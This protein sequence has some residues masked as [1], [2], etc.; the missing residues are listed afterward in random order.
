M[1]DRASSV[2][3]IEFSTLAKRPRAELLALWQEHVQPGVPPRISRVLMARAIAWSIQAHRYG[4]YSF[5]T[6]ERLKLL[7]GAK[8]TGASL[9]PGT[10]LVR[11]WN[12]V[13]HEV[14]V[15]EHGYSWRGKTY[16]SLSATACAITGTKWSGPRF[17]GVSGRKS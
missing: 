16:R 2:A 11:E 12:G 10:K 3:D 15:L 13:A 8:Q 1:I 17:F 9:E 7:T 6:R 5:E 4:G 14:I